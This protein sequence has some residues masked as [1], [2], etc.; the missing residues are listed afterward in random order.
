MVFNNSKKTKLTLKYA[1]SLVLAAVYLFSLSGCGFK[2]RGEYPLPDEFKTLYVSSVDTHGE[3][4][5]K[6]KQ[7]LKNNQV[8][9]EKKYTGQVPELRILKDTLDRR[10]L[11]LFENG[12]VAEYELIYTIKYQLIIQDKE[13]LEFEFKLYRDYQEDPD[14][15]L[16]KSRELNLMLS[17][18]RVD[19][20]N[21]ILREMATIKV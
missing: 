1:A 6:V 8:V 4:T 10:T 11:S 21:R 7:H 9:I 5:R 18:M 19:A 17:E 3:L 14:R 16:A 13:P 15:A 12:Q 20:A 2:L